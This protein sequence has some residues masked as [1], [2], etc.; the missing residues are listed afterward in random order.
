MAGMKRLIAA[1]VVVAG[2]ALPVC[3]QR[4]GGSAG[5]RGGS[6]SHA[7]SFVGHSAP[8]FRGSV[9]TMGRVNFMGAP[10]V[11]SNRSVAAPR[12][13]SRSGPVA[14]YP[15]HG[16]GSADRRN[17]YRRPYSPAYGFPTGFSIWPGSLL[18][19]GFYDGPGFY[20]N[21]GYVDSG[22]A[23]PAPPAVYGPQ[24]YA[25]PPEEQAEV[26]QPGPYRPAYQTPQP[27]PEPEAALTLVFKDGRPTEEIHNYMLTRT[28]LYV[29]DEHRREIPVDDL[30]LGA[31]QKINK[32]NGIDFQLPGVSR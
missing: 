32:S 25:A 27:P 3:A 17:G 12:L 20:N 5:Y 1:A 8:A 13:S 24:P 19:S 16:S 30:D 4:G 6:A 31:T 22:Y 10:Q 23:N 14:G 18:D 26:A 28:T 7:S 29:Q 15:G 2:V 11:S 21:S 9:P